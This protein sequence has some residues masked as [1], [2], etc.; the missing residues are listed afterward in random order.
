MIYNDSCI[1]EPKKKIMFHVLDLQK[2]IDMDIAS[3]ITYEIYYRVKEPELLKTVLGY[4]INADYSKAD[5]ENRLGSIAFDAITEHVSMLNK[6]GISS[7]KFINKDFNLENHVMET[8]SHSPFSEAGV[9]ICSF[10]VT[11]IRYSEDDIELFNS[12][13]YRFNSMVEANK[14]LEDLKNSSNIKSKEKE[15]DDVLNQTKDIIARMSGKI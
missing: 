2:L 10:K 6:A 4:D 8:L 5:F 11:Q 14:A 15:L 7:E 9:K 3:E 12:I 13:I 1:F